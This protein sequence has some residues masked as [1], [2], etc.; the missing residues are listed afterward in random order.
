MHFYSDAMWV[1]KSPHHHLYRELSHTAGSWNNMSMALKYLSKALA[2][3]PH[4]VLPRT[5]LAHKGLTLP[6]KSSP[7]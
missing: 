5:E 1:R 4:M 2:I 7:E 6:M 3:A